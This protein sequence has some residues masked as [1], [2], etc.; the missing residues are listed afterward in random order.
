M[1]PCLWLAEDCSWHGNFLVTGN[2]PE[3]TWLHLVYPVHWLSKQVDM[4]AER[5]SVYKGV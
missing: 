1:N 2:F 4:G 3:T 5:S